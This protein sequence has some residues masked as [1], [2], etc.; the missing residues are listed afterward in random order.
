MVQTKLR[1]YWQTF[2]DAQNPLI[3]PW[4]PQ[5]SLKQNFYRHANSDWKATTKVNWK[6]AVD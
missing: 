3:N 1:Q 2:G 4:M 6:T 5:V